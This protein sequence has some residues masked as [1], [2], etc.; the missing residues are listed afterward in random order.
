MKKNLLNLEFSRDGVD[1]SLFV[2]KHIQKMTQ[3]AETLDLRLHLNDLKQ[4]TTAFT[5]KSAFIFLVVVCF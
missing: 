3:K 1:S 2:A 4:E 5:P